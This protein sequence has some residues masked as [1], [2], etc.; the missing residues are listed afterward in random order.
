MPLDLG[1]DR[2]GACSAPAVSVQNN[3]EHAAALTAVSL[4]GST[5]RGPGPPA[6][7]LQ[8]TVP[9]RRGTPAGPKG[10]AATP[11]SSGRI[12]AWGGGEDCGSTSCS[13]RHPQEGPGWAFG[14]PKLGTG[15]PLLAAQ[16]ASAPQHEASPACPAEL[17]S[18]ATPWWRGLDAPPQR[19]R[20]VSGRRWGAAQR[21]PWERAPCGDARCPLCQETP[22]GAVGSGG[23][24]APSALH[25]GSAHPESRA[26]DSLSLGGWA[27]GVQRPT[28][29]PLPVLCHLLGTRGVLGDVLCPRVRKRPHSEP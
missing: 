2:L 20:S 3:P 17:T 19:Q 1:T 7:A 18:G 27:P 29:R 24:Q 5:P 14:G 25:L 23:R 13:G 12:R 22:G 4:A 28:A 16:A 26:T 21:R 8:G 6:V 9:P 10:R 15:C 11:R